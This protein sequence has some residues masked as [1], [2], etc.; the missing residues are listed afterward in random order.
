MGA[1][2]GNSPQKDQHTQADAEKG[3]EYYVQHV[4]LNGAVLSSTHLSEMRTESTAD[5]SG[6]LSRTWTIAQECTADVED[7][8]MYLKSDSSLFIACNSP[9]YKCVS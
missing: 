8:S 7:S 3:L 2:S 4:P 9:E 6:V 5:G 1:T